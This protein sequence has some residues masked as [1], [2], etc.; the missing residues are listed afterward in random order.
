MLEGDEYYGAEDTAE[1]VPAG[2]SEGDCWIWGG[3]IGEVE[4]YLFGGVVSDWSVIDR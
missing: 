1:G 3:T 2:S 4:D